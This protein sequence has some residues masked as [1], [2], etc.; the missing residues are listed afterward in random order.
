MP[1][2]VLISKTLILAG[3]FVGLLA[4]GDGSAA[5]LSLSPRPEPAQSFSGNYL[6]AR[7]AQRS[8]DV[9]AEALFM[10]ESL[11][12]NP[13]DPQLLLGAFNASLASGDIEEGVTLANRI[14]IVDPAHTLAR[15]VIGVRAMRTGRCDEARRDFSHA[16][17]GP[18]EL[19]AVTLTAWCWLAEGGADQALELLDR[20]SDERFARFR[21]YHAALIA[22]ARGYT[23]ETRKRLRALYQAD[24]RVMRTVDAWGRFLARTG[25]YDQAKQVFQ[26]YDAQFPRN[27]LVTAALRDLEAGK[28]LAPLTPDAMFGAAEALY[29]LGA[30]GGQQADPTN[31]LIFM[32]LAV[33]LAPDHAL[34]W[35][36]LGEINARLRQPE[37][38]IEAY[39]AISRSS[40]L[41][42]MA[43][44]QTALLLQ[45]TGKADEAVALIASSMQARPNDISAVETLGDLYRTQKKWIDAVQA[46]GKG[47]EMLGEPK[48]GDWRWFYFRGVAYERSGQWPL[49]EADFK[50]ALQL[51]PEQPQVLN[52]L[53]YTWADRNENLQEALVM[54]EKAAKLANRDGHI[55]D[56]L[57]WV[58][59][60][61]GRYEDALRE[62]ERAVSMVPAEAVVN[63][64][65]GDVYWK[66][67][68][69]REAVFKWRH[70][71]ALNPE[72]EEVERINRK[73]KDAAEQ[74]AASG[75]L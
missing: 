71:L 63:E 25:Q 29:G 23:Y 22:D 18:L 68:R 37:R 74:L 33:F 4:A 49:A 64:H 54:L 41:R 36:S 66:V 69:K 19:P 56:S 40:P 14:L 5:P 32:R 34:A 62:L 1:K 2:S 48:P 24:P 13:T 65:L 59:Y 58:Y 47:I 57:G 75:G 60:R 15:F 72:P 51:N 10:R 70:A 61:L 50:R 28:L 35:T 43:D 16:A 52:Y 46:Y 38:A 42:A 9:R 73:M 67:G 21:D 39:S 26:A 20:V 6:A 8:K 30:S 3:A 31:S 12:R 45:S 53:A 7:L 27:P 17:K 55:I 11:R 44:N